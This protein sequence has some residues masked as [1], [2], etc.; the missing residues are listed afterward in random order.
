MRWT[1]HSAFRYGKHSPHRETRPSSLDREEQTVWDRNRGDS[2]RAV[3]LQ[4]GPTA[5]WLAA[6][7]RTVHDVQ[8]LPEDPADRRRVLDQHGGR[9]DVL[10]VSGRAMVG[11]SLLAEL[12]HLGLIA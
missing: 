3:V 12:P 9:I 8:V 7:L 1:P 6:S 4:T 10:A 5:P 11:D 2:A